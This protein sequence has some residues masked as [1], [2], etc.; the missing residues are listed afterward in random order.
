MSRRPARLALVSAVLM[1]AG[2]TG[3][4]GAEPEDSMA[5]KARAYLTSALD[6]MEKHSLM[7]AEVDW[8]K[9]RRDAFAH[10]AKARTPA[11]TYGPIR[12]ALRDLGDRHSTFLD[13]QDVARTQD[14]SADGLMLP[15]GRRLPGGIGYLML[16]PVASDEVAAPYIRAARSTVTG[17]DDEGACG[18]VV[19]L[20]GESGGDM[21]PPLAA[22]GPILGDGEAGAAVYADG[23]KEAWAVQDGTPSTYLDTW[24]AATP[25]A[26]PMPPVAVLTSRRTASAGEAVVISFLGRPGTRT[27]GQ[28]TTGVPTANSAY[29]LSDGA[30]VVVT[31]AREADRTGLVHDGPLTPD[32]E[33]PETR[34]PDKALKA[35]T[36]WLS[37]QEPCRS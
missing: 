22:V 28:A 33:I 15:E 37:G 14:A 11:E 36:A 17:I 1:V 6:L 21:W 24:G 20:R 10:A 4:G 5:P 18:W 9:V 3:G 12:Q 35:A 31:V 16:P 2:C 32:V 7:K 34:G 29:R 19:D 30:M 23:R 27:F 25:L 13:P 8:P 26:R